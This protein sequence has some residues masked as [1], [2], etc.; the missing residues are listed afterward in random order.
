MDERD[1]PGRKRMDSSIR[2]GGEEEDWNFLFESS[3]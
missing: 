2:D 1:W 3:V